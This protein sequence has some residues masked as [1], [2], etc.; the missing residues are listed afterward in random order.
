MKQ[1]YRL[2][3]SI[4][5]IIVSV[6]L[7]S[8]A[9]WA[10]VE[11]VRPQK[12]REIQGPEQAG[13]PDRRRT[14]PAED[15]G[16]IRINWRALHL[17]SEQRE[18]IKQYRRDFQINTAGI[19]KEKQFAE[20]DLRSEMLKDSLDRAKIDSLLNDISSLKQRLSE[21]AVKNVLAI[22]SIL[23]QDQLEILADQQLRLPAELRGLKLPSEQREQVRDI[24]KES[25]QKRKASANEL[26]ELKAEL[27]EMLLA[28]GDDVDSNRLDQ[29]QNDIA[30]KELALDKNRV[31]SLLQLRE[32]LTPDQLKQLKQL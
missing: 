3:I 24:I 5:I 13:Q 20:R 19:R 31:D 26:Q 6:F 14:G 28:P 18:Q 25:M 9:G 32:I 7:C 30:A 12:L 2:S 16:G 1:Q 27:R 4:T 8:L 15:D 11:N 29:L 10:Q 23:T 17:T 22:K 21:A